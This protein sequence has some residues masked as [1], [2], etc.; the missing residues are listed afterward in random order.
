[1]YE[2]PENADIILDTASINAV[3]LTDQIIKFLQL[4]KII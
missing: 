1:L 3:E 2:E 4:K